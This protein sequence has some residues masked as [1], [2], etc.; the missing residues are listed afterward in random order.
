[1]NPFSRILM[2]GAVSI[3]ILVGLHALSSNSAILAGDRAWAALEDISSLSQKSPSSLT[4]IFGTVPIAQAM[5]VTAGFV[6]VAA[7]D[8]GVYN[9]AAAS[10]G[11]SLYMNGIAYISAGVNLE[12]N[13]FLASFLPNR[14]K[15]V[16]LGVNIK[17]FVGSEVIAGKPQALNSDGFNADIALLYTPSNWL[18]IG[19]NQQNVLPSS[20]SGTSS[21]S[22]AEDKPSVTTLGGDIALMGP[23]GLIKSP[24]ALDVTLNTDLSLLGIA[25]HV[26]IEYKPIEWLSLSGGLDQLATKTGVMTNPSIGLGFEYAGLCFKYSYQTSLNGGNGP[27]HSFSVSFGSQQNSQK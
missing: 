12:N 2:V 8:T 24:Q 26:G 3:F 20:L 21:K 4:E 17:L 25:G 1:M 14:G 7:S 9:D 11:N 10:L 16:L 13:C 6:T 22:D 27:A 23:K 5:G 19:L 18:S 15:D